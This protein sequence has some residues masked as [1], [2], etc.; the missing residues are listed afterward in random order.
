MDSDLDSAAMIAVAR[1]AEA[2]IIDT[3]D[4]FLTPPPKIP[5]RIEDES[6]QWDCKPAIQ[7]D[8]LQREANNQSLGGAGERTAL[9][10]ELLR[11]RSEGKPRLA[12]RV[13]HCS[14]TRGDGLGFDI[15]SFETDGRERFIE[16]KT[17][18]FG[19]E[20]PF[21]L[22]EGERVFSSKY[23]AQFHLY[24]IFDF[25]KRPKMYVLP[26]AIDQSCR[27]NAVSYLALP[28]V[29]S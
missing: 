22:S 17:T 14:K 7:R 11:L 28:A 26:G 24:R 27:L 9:E 15:L 19:A 20:T 21:F 23:R 25:R 16:V 18:A 6:E 8:Y 5:W 3:F 12:D 4:A 29:A 10:F 13:E 2:P 1:P